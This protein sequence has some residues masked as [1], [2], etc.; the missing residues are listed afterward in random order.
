MGNHEAK[1][2]VNKDPARRRTLQEIKEVVELSGYPFEIALQQQFERAGMGGSTVRVRVSPE[3]S[4]EVD[5]LASAGTSRLMSAD[6]RAPGE[7][8]VAV[9]SNVVTLVEA[10]R[11]PSPKEFVGFKSRE[12]TEDERLHSRLSFCAVPNWSMH[13]GP[14][15]M[16][17][18]VRSVI[19]CFD[20]LIG[21]DWCSQWGILT[22]DG[23]R[24]EVNHEPKIW[25]AIHDLVWAHRASAKANAAAWLSL[26]GP[27]APMLE[28]RLPVVA[29]D[30]PC[31]H[32]Y[33]VS[34]GELRTSPHL[35]VYGTMDVGGDLQSQVF[36][37]VCEP[38]MPAF[39]SAVR[40]VADNLVD[41]A[42][43]DFRSFWVAGHMQRK[44]A[45]EE[46]KRRII[47]R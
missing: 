39:I 34:S 32:V 43:N 5:V 7:P 19:R 30:L 38:A 3:K 1:D 31:L 42:I 14:S 10:K 23:T 37:V 2:T 20:P 27:V 18:W 46:R 16:P 12:P 26:D 8:M 11:F 45:A 21:G 35:V 17:P 41:T 13:D 28:V 24:L 44:E 47:E 22:R 25:N 15:P 9:Q 36:D 33:D 40:A 29:I 6:Q 4:V